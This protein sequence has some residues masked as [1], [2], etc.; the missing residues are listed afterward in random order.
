M[1]FSAGIFNPRGEGSSE[2]RVI[3]NHRHNA[4]LKLMHRTRKVF[5]V[6]VEKTSIAMQ[7]RRLY[8]HR[9]QVTGIVDASL[10]RQVQEL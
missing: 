8:G 5:E 6:D 1:L 4:H 10:I 9:G 7:R 2:I 3:V